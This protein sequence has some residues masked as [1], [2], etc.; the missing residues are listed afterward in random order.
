MLRV[1]WQ[2]L[3]CLCALLAVTAIATAAVPE[4]PRFRELGPADG[5]PSTMVTALAR[6]HDGF[7][8]AATWDGLARYDGVGFQVWRHDPD[9]PASLPGN[10]LQ[11]MYVDGRNRVWVASEGGGVSVMDA[12]RHH[13]RHF[14]KAQHPQMESD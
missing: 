12:D 8:W 5:L 7:L 3:M 2:R 9:D 1:C 4:I 14:R 10:L 11:A 13:F 6:D